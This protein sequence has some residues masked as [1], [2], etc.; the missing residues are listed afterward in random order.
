M[1]KICTK[2]K[3]EKE[4]SEFSKDKTQKDGLRNK[5][6]SCC[7]EYR[8]ANKEIIKEKNKKY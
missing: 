7:K 2:C 1:I 8:Q 4:L 3:I 5:C 6:K